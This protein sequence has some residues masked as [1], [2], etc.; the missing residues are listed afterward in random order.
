MDVLYSLPQAD[1]KTLSLRR[2]TDT[3]L[4]PLP[5]PVTTGGMSLT[6]AL[7]TRRSVRSFRDDNPLKDTEISQLLWA[8]QGETTA[9]GYRTAPSA[10]AKYP[11]EVMNLISLLLS[12]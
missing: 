4:V 7:S 9:G 1:T 12:T 10:G 5:T 6:E 8:T 3:H 11:L 2:Y